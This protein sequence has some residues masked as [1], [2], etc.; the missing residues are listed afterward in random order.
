MDK[1]LVRRSIGI[2]FSGFLPRIF[3]IKNE[4]TAQA[5]EFKIEIISNKK[6]K[7]LKLINYQGPKLLTNR[8]LYHSS[9][10]EEMQQH[11]NRPHCPI[12]Q[13]I[14]LCKSPWL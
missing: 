12:Y 2:S 10:S 9:R 5:V 1:V 8:M 7:C 6:K 14:K 3:G 4:S 11:L 13:C